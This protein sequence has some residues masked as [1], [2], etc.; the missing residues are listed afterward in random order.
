MEAA[1]DG[2]LD[3]V[4][5]LPRE[6]EHRMG[7]PGLGHSSGQGLCVLQ[8]EGERSAGSVRHRAGPVEEEGNGDVSANGA[9]GSVDAPG[10][11]HPGGGQWKL[12]GV[13]IDV[14]LEPVG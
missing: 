13:G 4:P 6:N 11:L 12:Q 3:A 7:L 5:G 1:Q 2:H 8:L 14:E 9:D 10:A